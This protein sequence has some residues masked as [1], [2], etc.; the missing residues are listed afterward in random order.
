MRS[1]KHAA[2]ADAAVI[3]V[4]DPEFGEA[5]MAFVELVPGR[6][7]F[8]GRAGRALPRAY[9]GLQE[10]QACELRRSASA[11]YHR[12]GHEGSAARA[13]KA[14]TAGIVREERITA[15]GIVGRLPAAALAISQ[16]QAPNLSPC[17]SLPFRN[18][19][20]LGCPN[21]KAK[22][23]S[24]T[25]LYAPVKRFL[26]AQG[27]SVKGEVCGCDLVALRGD[28]PPVVVIGELKLKFNLELVLQ[29]VERRAS[30]DEVWLAVRVGP[31]GGREN[32]RRVRKLCRLLGFGLLG[33][34]STGRVEVLVEPTPWKPRP[35]RKRRA[36][37]V[38]E[39]QRRNGDPVSGGMTKVPIMTAYRQQA[40][41][42]A[43]MLQGGP[44]PHV[45]GQGG[46]AGWAEDPAAQRLWLVRSG[47]ARRLSADIRR[48]C[49]AGALAA[50][51]RFVSSRRRRQARDAHRARWRRSPCK[52]GARH[53]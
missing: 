18:S 14:R 42:C 19:R 50:A 32:D 24:E 34:F 10:A 29:G 11:Q 36:R 44:C 33:V 20:R 31:R 53:L 39:H 28:E 38:R 2:V 6:I 30:C 4:P 12:Q 27:F 21:A 35:D 16:F 52:P 43:A 5:V 40:L 25:A 3:A 22:P 8:A 47:R 1:S 15:W 13:G 26:E 45:A 49:G 37:L 41:L 7:G 9:R 51:A 23:E 48:R 17:P 46:G